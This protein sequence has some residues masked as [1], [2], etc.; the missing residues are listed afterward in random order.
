MGRTNK[1]YIFAANIDFVHIT[2]SYG[3]GTEERKQLISSLATEDG[4]FLH[5]ATKVKY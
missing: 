2:E 3:G 4:T 1:L 5:M